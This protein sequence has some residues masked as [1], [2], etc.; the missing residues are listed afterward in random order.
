MDLR[1]FSGILRGDV[2]TAIKASGTVGDRQTTIVC[3][4]EKNNI[5]VYIDGVKDKNI[6]NMLD[7]M[8]GIAPPMGGTY[9]PEAGTMQAYYNVLSTVFFTKLNTIEVEGEL[10]PIPFEEDVIY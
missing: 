3:K 9:Y 10:E 4:D 8:I 1:D 6:I 5:T 7:M 2:M